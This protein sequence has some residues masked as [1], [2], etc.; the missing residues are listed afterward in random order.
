MLENLEAELMIK[1]NFS[2]NCSEFQNFVK[3]EGVV[4]LNE[5]KSS[6]KY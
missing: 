3:N 5:V 1:Q 2:M 4:I 6:D